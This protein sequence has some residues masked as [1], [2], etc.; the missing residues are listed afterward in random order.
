[1]VRFVEGTRLST[2]SIL[3]FLSLFPSFTK[4]DDF[5]IARHVVSSS[6][7]NPG[8]PGILSVVSFSRAVLR[9]GTQAII[10]YRHLYV[11]TYITMS[12]T[13]HAL[14]YFFCSASQRGVF[15]SRRPSLLSTI[16]RTCQI[17]AINARD[18]AKSARSK[19][20]ASRR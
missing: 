11:R 9:R 3:P 2:V 15:R 20:C 6:L 18:V 8:F 12:R 14:V 10:V 4:V 19:A 13:H 17:G 7:A 5:T 1:M 16:G